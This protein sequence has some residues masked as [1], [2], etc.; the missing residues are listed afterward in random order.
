MITIKEE[1]QGVE[2]EQEVEE[3]QDDG[4]DEEQDGVEEEALTCHRRK[5]FCMMTTAHSC[6]L[7]CFSS[8]MC[9]LSFHR[10]Q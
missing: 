8:V 6:F 2:E 4:V 9:D 7:R 1:E 5:C 10:F 3:E